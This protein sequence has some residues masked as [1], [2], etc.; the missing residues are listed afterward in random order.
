[1]LYYYSKYERTTYRRLWEKY[2]Q[3][4]RVEELNALFDPPMAAD[5]YNDVVHTKTEWPTR[6]Y[7]IKALAK[8]LGFHW[9]D[10]HTPPPL[11]SNGTTAGLRKGRR[12]H[13][14]LQ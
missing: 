14:R 2:P 1:M 9:R 8:Y 12:T 6:D 5:L 11:P 7:S 3:V 10:P 4:C 13:P